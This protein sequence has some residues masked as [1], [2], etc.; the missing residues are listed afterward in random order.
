MQTLPIKSICAIV[1]LFLLAAFFNSVMDVLQFRY[2][3]S[4]FARQGMSQEFF[5]PDIS[6]RNKW[7]NG[8]P[9]EGEAYP[10]SSTVFVLFTDAWHLFQFLM[11]T[12]FE[13]IILILV[14]RIWKLK[15]YLY[16]PIFIAMKFSFG[17]TFE[18]FFT[19][20]LISGN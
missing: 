4:V 14:H 3:K 7:K 13:L 1:C 17:L 5:N 9:E 18:L 20:V 15:W 2:S 10:G 12:C 11:F 19:K 8:K 6:W 16:I